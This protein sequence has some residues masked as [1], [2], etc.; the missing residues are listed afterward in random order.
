MPTSARAHPAIPVLRIGGR[1]G[2]VATWQRTL[3]FLIVQARAGGFS[4]RLAHQPL[5]ANDGVFG[6]HTQAATRCY[7]R[8]Y[9]LAVNGT[10]G[11]SDWT[12]WIE[13]QLTGRL[14]PAYFGVWSPTVTWWQASLDR[15]L[16][17]HAPG[18]PPLIPDGAYGPLTRQATLDF[19]RWAG[20]QADGQAGV[21]TE[22]RLIAVL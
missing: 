21:V 18:I 11:W 9:R 1:S 5:L 14:F 6:P 8:T 22:T 12:T 19:Q 2:E 16:A 15:W 3:D 20:I 4:P 17:R 10:V 7:E 13:G